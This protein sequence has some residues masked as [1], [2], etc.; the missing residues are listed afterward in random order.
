M[1]KRG[2][3]KYISSTNIENMFRVAVE[4]YNFS[5][6]KKEYSKLLEIINN[7]IFDIILHDSS[8]Y[9]LPK[10]LGSIRIKRTKFKYKLDENGR[11]KKNQMKVDFNSSKKLWREKY[12]NKTWQEIK[13]IPDKPLIYYLNKH[14]NNYYNKFYWDKRTSTLK[15][16]SI[17]KLDIIRNRKQELSRLSKQNKIYYE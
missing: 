10:K 17:Y 2:K 13:E 15:N 12:P 9:R 4:K 16:Q 1:Y 11:V 5:L 7:Y 6:D 3:R 8:E 14:T